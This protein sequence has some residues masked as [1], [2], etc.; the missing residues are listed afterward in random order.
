MP[1]GYALITFFA[2]EFWFFSID[3]AIPGFI[4]SLVAACLVY[5]PL[6]EYVDK[7]NFEK[8]RPLTLTYQIPVPKAY[9]V[10]KKILRTFVI[11]ERNWTL[12][13]ADKHGYNI[14]AM[15][16]WHDRSWRDFPLLAPDGMLFRQIILYIA[17]AK[18]SQTGLTDVQLHW[19]IDSPISRQEC[20]A[21]QYYTAQAIINGL[22]YAKTKVSY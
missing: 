7:Q 16:R 12:M 20:D 17:I 1:F 3:H 2:I 11:G 22:E 8:D 13:D 21:L 5:F 15:C 4:V 14:T 9:A 19:S 10:I 18:N 6:Q